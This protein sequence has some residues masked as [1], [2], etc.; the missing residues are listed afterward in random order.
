MYPKC[1]RLKKKDIYE[2]LC[3]WIVYHWILPL[4]PRTMAREEHMFWYPRLSD[5]RATNLYPERKAF[6]LILN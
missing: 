6:T 2:S 3:I 4:H 5:G 1:C